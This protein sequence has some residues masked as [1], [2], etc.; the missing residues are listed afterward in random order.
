[1][2]FEQFIKDWS[3]IKMLSVDSSEWDTYRKDILCIW[4]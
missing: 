4:S 3:I 1:M 2:R